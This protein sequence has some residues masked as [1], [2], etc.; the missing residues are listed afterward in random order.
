MSKKSKGVILSLAVIIG[1]F[2]M[3]I[4]DAFTDVDINT[5]F[6]SAVILAGLGGSAVIGF[7]K[8]RKK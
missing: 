5:S 8:Y 3:I 4:L 2:T 1:G 7:T 6:A